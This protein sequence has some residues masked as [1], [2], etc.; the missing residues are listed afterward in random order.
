MC[1]ELLTAASLVRLITLQ[2][3]SGRPEPLQRFFFPCPVV[4][5]TGEEAEASGKCVSITSALP[6]P[7]SKL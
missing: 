7:T 6:A 2:A 5:E 1:P 4:W 3:L